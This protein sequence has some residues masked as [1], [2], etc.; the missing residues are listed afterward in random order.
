MNQ[1]LDFAIEAHGG[2]ERWARH[3]K[4]GRDPVIFGLQS[5]RMSGDPEGLP[6]ITARIEM[7]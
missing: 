5:L 1:L 2:L 7:R 6:N 3:A 4:T